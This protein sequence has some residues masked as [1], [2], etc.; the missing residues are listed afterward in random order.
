MS[1]RHRSPPPLFES[2]KKGKTQMGVTNQH[3][4]SSKDPIWF[5]FHDEV[6]KMGASQLHGVNKRN[7]MK[8][9]FEAEGRK[10]TKNQKA[11]FK[12]L[13]GMRQK[14]KERDVKR[15]ERLKESGMLRDFQV[16]PL[17]PSGTPSNYLY[18][19]PEKYGQKR[20]N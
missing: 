6:M 10:P 5:N 2:K 16:W 19:L 12:M 9:K 13:L 14:Q 3:G 15:R 18:P 20:V 8:K 7:F 11:P 17:L 4:A 1:K